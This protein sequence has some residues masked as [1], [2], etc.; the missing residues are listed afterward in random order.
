L[1]NTAAA[2]QGINEAFNGNVYEGLFKLGDDG[3]VSPLLA[4]EYKVSDDG[5]VF[6]VTLHSGVQFHSGKALTSADVRMSFERVISPD[7]QAAR[8][9][10]YAVVEKIE[11]PDARTVV[12]YL[13]AS[14][15]TRLVF[16]DA[17]QF[18]A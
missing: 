5:L 14:L 8:K 18:S 6:T 15:K 12:F 10:S 11:T 9:S 16:R 4:S 17:L 7:S 13:R 2:G 1:S 3:S